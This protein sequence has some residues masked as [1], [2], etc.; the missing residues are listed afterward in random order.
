[1]TDNRPFATM[2]P[3]KAEVYCARLGKGGPAAFTLTSFQLFT[4]PFVEAIPVHNNDA[5]DVKAIRGYVMNNGGKQYKIYRGDMH[6]H[7]D[8]SQ[9]FKYDGSLLEGYRYGLDA[10]AFDYIA[11]TDHQTGYDQE[12]TWWQNQKLVDLFLIAGSFTPLYGSERSLNFPNGHRNTIF[13]HRGVR[14]LPIPP[15][16]ASAKTGAGQAVSVSEEEQ[17]HLHAAL[18]GH[19]PG[20]RLAR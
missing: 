8:V 3:K 2:I 11:L 12:F 17:R 9:D 14:T 10:A 4:E 1:M 16:E 6:R 19:Q 13:A 15:E 7:T 20:H 5:A 18:L